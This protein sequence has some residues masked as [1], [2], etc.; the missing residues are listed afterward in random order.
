MYHQHS[1]FSSMYFL[2]RNAMRQTIG[3]ARLGTSGFCKGG[4]PDDPARAQIRHAKNNLAPA[5]IGE[6]HAILYEFLEMEVVFGFLEF[7]VRALWFAEPLLQL[8]EACVQDAHCTVSFFLSTI[9]IS[10]F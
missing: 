4:C 6:G 2:N 9:S 3:Q 5:L 1:S 7:E 10:S 8:F